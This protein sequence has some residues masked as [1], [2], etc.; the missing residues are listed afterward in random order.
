MVPERMAAYMTTWQHVLACV[1]KSNAPDYMAAM[2]V[3]WVAAQKLWREHFETMCIFRK[4]CE[5]NPTGCS[6]SFCLVEKASYA[7]KIAKDTNHSA[8]IATTTWHLSWSMPST[9]YLQSMTLL[10][11]LHFSSIVQLDKCL[12]VNTTSTRVHWVRMT[13]NRMPIDENY[14]IHVYQSCIAHV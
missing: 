2:G 3:L 5:G 1:T 12:R 11:A 14:Q 4:A 13:W 10:Q 6:A 8:S 9:T 7:G